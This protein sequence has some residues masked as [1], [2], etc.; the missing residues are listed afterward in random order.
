MLLKN[1]ICQKQSNSITMNE[2]Y[3]ELVTYTKQLRSYLKKE[4]GADHQFGK[5]NQSSKDYTY[6]SMAPKE[7]K[8]IKLKFVIIYDRIQHCFTICLSGQNKDVRKKYWDI[9]K[10]NRKN[11]Y[12]TAESIDKS[13]MIIDHT[14]IENPML[15]NK[16]ELNRKI[17]KEATIFM[18]EI[19]K[20]LE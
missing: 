15:K 19:K 4:F 17:K 9:F 3:H 20:L 6:F 12:H 18:D 16:E 5:L 8:N 2:D 10:S 1:K 13:L 11:K 14:I 7:L